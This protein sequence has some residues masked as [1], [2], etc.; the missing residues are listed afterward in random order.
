MDNS[1][2]F[3]PGIPFHKI[4]TLATSRRKR[5]SMYWTVL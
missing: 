3:L 1:I 5:K 2:N 4:A